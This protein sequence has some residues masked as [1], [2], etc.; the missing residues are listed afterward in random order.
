[1]FIDGTEYNGKSIIKIYIYMRLS[2]IQGVK[3]C[4]EIG[5]D[6]NHRCN[7]GEDSR[8]NFKHSKLG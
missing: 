1:M 5:W 4:G 2:V 7:S 8:I 3:K 6:G